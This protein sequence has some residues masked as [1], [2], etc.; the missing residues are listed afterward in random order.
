MSLVINS[1]LEYLQ[2]RLRI[3]P[4]RM[5]LYTDKTIE[6]ILQSEAAQ[7][8]QAAIQLA[9]DMFTDPKQLVE[10]FQLADPQN[11]FVILQA[12]TTN[13]REQV[14]P[15]LNVKDMLQGLQFF[16]QERLLELLEKIPMEELVKTVF[17]MFSQKQVIEFM[18]EEQLN[19]LLTSTDMDK[20]L[21]LTKLQEIPEVYIQQMLE[22]VTGEQAQEN[23][24]SLAAQVGQLGDLQYKTALQNLDSTQKRELTLLITSTDEKLYEKFDAEAYTGFIGRE[25]N[26]HDLIEAMEVI[27]PEHLQKM[28]GKLPDDL[29]SIVL[30]QVES[31]KFADKLINEFPELLARFIAG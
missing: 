31:E 20:D 3:P 14:I 18:P 1:A 11:K 30:T 10:L 22:S 21:L 4:E 9:T 16:S 19:K 25:R 15:L 2:L 29:L 27:K 17:Q 23:A 5:N 7:G 6:E 8:N 28:I 13:Q 24:Q 26:K 12:M